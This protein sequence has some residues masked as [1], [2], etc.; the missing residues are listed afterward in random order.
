MQVILK[1]DSLAALDQNLGYKYGNVS[2]PYEAAEPSYLVAKQ[3]QEARHKEDALRR[4]TYAGVAERLIEV[5]SKL[6]SI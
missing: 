4:E 3:E 1:E 6:N 5:C 2:L